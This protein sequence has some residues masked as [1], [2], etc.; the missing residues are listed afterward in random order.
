MT[1]KVKN[2]KKETETERANRI[3]QQQKKEQRKYDEAK[4]L[5]KPAYKHKT[6][7]VI[8]G[9]GITFSDVFD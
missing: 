9:R 5:G 2:K 1:F 7:K 4:A 8:R 3:F 6:G